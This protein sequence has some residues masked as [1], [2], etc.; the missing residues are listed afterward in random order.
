MRIWGLL[1]GCIDIAEDAG[2]NAADD[3][4]V[5]NVFRDDGSGCDDGVTTDAHALQNGGVR[6][7]PHV[8]AQDDRCG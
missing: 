8:L 5:G 1:I 4:V 6:T 7:D 2:R 3:G